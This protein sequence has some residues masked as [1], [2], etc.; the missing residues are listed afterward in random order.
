MYRLSYILSVEITLD[1]FLQNNDDI[2]SW[3]NESSTAAAAL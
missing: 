3:A 1:L 2:I